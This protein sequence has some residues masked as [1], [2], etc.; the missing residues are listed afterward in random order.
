MT[1]EDKILI[2]LAKLKS[3]DEISPLGSVISYRA[4]YERTGLTVEEEVSIMNKLAADG[5]IEVTG[6]FGSETV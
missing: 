1:A 2:V 6:N 3:K 4:G 5:I